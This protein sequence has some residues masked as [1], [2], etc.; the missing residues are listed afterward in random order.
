MDQLFPGA[1]TLRSVPDKADLETLANLENALAGSRLGARARAKRDMSDLL[2]TTALRLFLDRGFDNV[3]VN[4]IAAAADVASRTFFR[5]FPSKETVI[6][7]AYDQMN[8]RLVD[9]VG[10]HSEKP[11]LEAVRDAVRRWFEECTPF[12]NLLS[13]FPFT[14]PTVNAALLLR[15]SDWEQRLAE[16]IAAS[17]PVPTERF[18]Q[19]WGTLT[20]T[21]VHLTHS[22]A[23][24]KGCSSLEVLDEVFDDFAGAVAG[25]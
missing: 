12:L 10:N 13:R 25:R 15:Q 2:R 4:E 9:L 7:D 6:V 19:I 14:S 5:Y 8:S 11:M 24:E 17:R 1:G 18:A 23:Q 22:T 20:F 3:T 16:A 21:L